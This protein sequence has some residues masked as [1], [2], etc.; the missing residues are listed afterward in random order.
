MV[1]NGNIDGPVAN[2]DE[3]IIQQACGPQYQYMRDAARNAANLPVVQ[4]GLDRGAVSADA[5]PWCVFGQLI[6]PCYKRLDDEKTV[7]HETVELI[8]T[9]PGLRRDRERH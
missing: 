3:A 6:S 8:A 1:V 9:Y 5:K 7:P 4:T 2:D